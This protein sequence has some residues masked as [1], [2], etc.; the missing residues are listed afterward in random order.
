[1]CYSVLLWWIASVYIE[2]YITQ[3]RA[4]SFFQLH[5][6]NADFISDDLTLDT[7]CSDFQQELAR[8]SLQIISIHINVFLGTAI[9]GLNVVESLQLVNLHNNP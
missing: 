3:L 9:I 4:L 5:Q 8:L 1:M 7:G 6:C 2:T